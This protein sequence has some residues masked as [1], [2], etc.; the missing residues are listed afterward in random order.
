MHDAKITNTKLLIS[1]C[2][3]GSHICECGKSSDVRCLGCP[4]SVCEHCIESEDIVEIEGGKGLC[5]KCLNLALMI[6]ENKTSD[7]DGVCRYDL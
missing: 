6:E 4:R 1:H 5:S 3:S 2:I 7:S